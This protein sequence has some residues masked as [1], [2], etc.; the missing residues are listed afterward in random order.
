MKI[1]YYKNGV[2]FSQADKSQYL[3]KFLSFASIVE[4][5]FKG[6]REGGFSLG[7][8]SNNGCEQCIV[9]DFSSAKSAYNEFLTKYNE[10]A[11]SE[12]NR[13]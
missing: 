10:W 8:Y 12:S 2:E 3:R 5:R 11:G 4:V 7:F 1:T 9:Y 13:E 6:E